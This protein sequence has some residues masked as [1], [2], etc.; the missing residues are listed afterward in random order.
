VSK[1]NNLK[2]LKL[3]CAFLSPIS[4]AWKQVGRAASSMVNPPVRIHSSQSTYFH[5]LCIAICNSFDMVGD[6]SKLKQ[7][8]KSPAKHFLFP[9]STKLLGESFYFQTSGTDNIRAHQTLTLHRC[10]ASR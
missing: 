1:I 3:E 5:N 8:N 9:I 7:M 10:A 6:Q 2:S 4:C